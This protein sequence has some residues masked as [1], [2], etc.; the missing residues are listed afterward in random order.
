[1]N[2]L[3]LPIEVQRL[4][5]IGDDEVL[6]TGI[7]PDYGSMGIGEEHIPVLMSILENYDDFSQQMDD[8]T[9]FLPMHA[10]RAL[11]TLK[12]DSAIQ[13]MLNLF[14]HEDEESDEVIGEDLPQ[15]MGRMGPA[16]YDPLN[17][18]LKDKTHG[19]R[20]RMD[21]A[22]ALMYYAIQ[23]PGDRLRVID[24]LA[25]AL[26]DYQTQDPSE[27]AILIGLL[28]NLNAVE[29]A[30]IVE[31]AYNSG[32]VEEYF[33]GDWEDWQVAV[34]LLKE[35][36][37]SPQ[38]SQISPASFMDGYEG[39]FGAPGKKK[40]DDRTKKK[41]KQAEKSKKVNRRKKKK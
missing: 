4:A 35:R 17:D 11:A 31:Q 39:R 9:G 29:A 15:A 7:W 24:D 36:Q 37:T 34:G 6:N 14:N 8:P 33:I 40:E 1:M 25:N 16:V 41:R 5:K 26:S 12:A 28:M 27:N 30:P 18:W 22:E 2:I 20:S 21:A 23:N 10:W 32:N 38:R 19:H 13:L 3:S